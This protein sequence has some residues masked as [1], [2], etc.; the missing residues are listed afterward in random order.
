[1]TNGVHAAER[2][3]LAGHGTHLTLLGELAR[4]DRRVQL[5]AT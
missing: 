5:K 1:M 3:S 4:T 2:W